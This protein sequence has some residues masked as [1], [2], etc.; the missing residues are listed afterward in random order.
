MKNIDL[1]LDLDGII[2]RRT[3]R[4][5]GKGRNEFAI[6]PGA[7]DFLSWAID[8]LPLNLPPWSNH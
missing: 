6:A 7:M 2:L 3:G 1:Y 4:T 5:A 8:L